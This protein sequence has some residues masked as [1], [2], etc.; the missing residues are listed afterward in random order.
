MPIEKAEIHGDDVTFE[1]HDNAGRVVGL[2]FSLIASV[3]RGEVEVGGQISKVSLFNADRNVYKTGNGVSAPVVIRKVGPAYTEEARRAKFE[4]MVL[5]S[6]EIDPNGTAT[7]IKVRI[8][9]G[10][11][12]DDKAIEALKQW[13]FKPGLKDGKPVTVA[14]TVEMHFRLLRK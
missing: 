10:L 4:G 5:L 13:E 3:L 11:G 6:A 9:V 8:S 2:R 7:N 1:V 14:V 12:L